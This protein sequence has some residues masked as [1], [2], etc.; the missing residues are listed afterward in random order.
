[1]EISSI[2][3]STIDKMAMACHE[4]NKAYCESIGDY[5]QVSWDDA[6]E[7]IKE[8]ARYGVMYRLMN[9]GSPPSA[10]HEVWREFKAKD[11]WVFGEEKDADKKTHPC[12]VP[13]EE[14]PQ[15]QK[16]K[17]YLFNATFKIATAMLGVQCLNS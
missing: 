3:K 6:A 8:S 14:L 5:T 1:M 7:N 2:D 12:M 16:S 11:G 13:Y 4:V 15:A 10:Q 17:D 9:P